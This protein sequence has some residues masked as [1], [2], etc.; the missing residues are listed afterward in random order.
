LLEV[1][2][3]VSS[4]FLFRVIGITAELCSS[5]APELC[6][7]VVAELC[8]SVVAELCSSVVAELCSSGVSSRIIGFSTWLSESSLESSLSLPSFSS[9]LSSLLPLSLL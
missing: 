8:S 6:S 5:G 4:N 1:S 2:F 7:S 9:S 3:S